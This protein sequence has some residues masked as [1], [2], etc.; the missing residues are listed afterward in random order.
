MTAH[1]LLVVLFQMR[2]YLRQMFIDIVDLIGTLL[3]LKIT[4]L[5]FKLTDALQSDL[6]VIALLGCFYDAIA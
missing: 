4:K 1:F 3:L 5:I 2:T 6:G